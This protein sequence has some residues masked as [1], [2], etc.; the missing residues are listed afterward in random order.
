MRQIT[1]GDI[2]D[3]LQRCPNLSRS[4][5]V[6]PFDVKRSLPRHA[7][8]SEIWE[9]YESRIQVGRIA[10]LEDAAAVQVSHNYLKLCEPAHRGAMTSYEVARYLTRFTADEGHAVQVNDGA[11]IVAAHLL[12]LPVKPRGHYAAIQVKAPVSVDFAILENV[13]FWEK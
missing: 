8:A 13:S 5:F 10:L 1:Y 7:S 12:N 11:V 6:S 2:F 4:G 3:V 9:A